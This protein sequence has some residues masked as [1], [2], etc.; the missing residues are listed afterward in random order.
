MLTSE[1]VEE[2]AASYSLMDLRDPLLDTKHE[3]FL[4]QLG[5][6]VHLKRH[7]HNM[8]GGDNRIIPHTLQSDK[9]VQWSPKGTYLII[10]KHDKVE[11]H[12]GKKMAPIITIPE[13]KVDF[14]SMS[15]CERYVMTYAPMAKNPYVIWNFQLVEQI[16]DF[17]QKEGEDGHAYL[18]SQDGNYLAKKFKQDIAKDDGT[19]KIKT[20]VSV[21]QLPSMELIQTSDGV[22]KSI[23]VDGIED[24]M[25]AP[26]RNFLVYT[27]F[28]GETQHPRVG[29]IEVPSRQTTIKTFNNSQALK[30]YFHPQGDYLGV[31]NEYKEKKTTK[32]SIELFDTKKQSFPHQQILINREVIRFNSCIW[33]PH[34][35]KLAI[36]TLAKRSIES[37]KK[38]YTLD[39]QRNGIDIYEMLDDPIKGFITKTI[40]F[41][42]SEKVTGFTWSGAGDIFAVVETESSKNSLNFYMISVEQ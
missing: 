23:T 42:P 26:N 25:W 20:G 33:E 18:W 41:L 9:N 19:T 8:V 36:H 14:V 39:A 22:K 24:I 28:P 30:L 4:Y 7:D 34:G 21:Y 1:S 17:D 3:Q 15:P 11:F 6:E 10:I 32:Y 2:T 27:A 29:F 13:Q 38:D 5:K 40:G 12:G 35:N 37:G 16:R 31:M